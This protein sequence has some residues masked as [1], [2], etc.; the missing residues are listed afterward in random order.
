MVSPL[1]SAYLNVNHPS[2]SHT[3]SVRSLT[4]PSSTLFPFPLPTP[5]SHIPKAQRDSTVSLLR[6]SPYPSSHLSTKAG[7]GQGPHPPF[8]NPLPQ[9]KARWTGALGDT[10]LVAAQEGISQPQVE[11]RHLHRAWCLVRCPIKRHLVASDTV[12]LRKFCWTRHKTSSAVNGEEKS[13]DML[14]ILLRYMGK[15]LERQGCSIFQGVGVVQVTPTN[16]LGS[17]TELG[18]Q[19]SHT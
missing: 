7:Q 16:K 11:I 3:S 15:L 17:G 1:P 5:T 9:F 19:G 12:S 4:L 10:W 14:T 2:R 8:E 13:S 6:S 18:R